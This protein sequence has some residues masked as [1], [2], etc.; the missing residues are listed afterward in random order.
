MI[1]LVSQEEVVVMAERAAMVRLIV[2]ALVT[3]LLVIR[4]HVSLELC[5]GCGLVG[6]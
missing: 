4:F 1:R 5:V 2:W 6:G 3:G